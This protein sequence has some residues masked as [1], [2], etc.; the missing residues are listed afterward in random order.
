MD[1]GVDGALDNEG[2]RIGVADREVESRLH[3]SLEGEDIE[4]W[5]ACA[6]CQVEAKEPCA[7]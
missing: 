2:I 7:V 6:D 4:A 3:L 1:R 5:I